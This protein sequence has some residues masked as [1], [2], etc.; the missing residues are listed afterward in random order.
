MLPKF[1]ADLSI[2]VSYVHLSLKS[3]RLM[4]HQIFEQK[5]MVPLWN[6]ANWWFVVLAIALSNAPLIGRFI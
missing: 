6:L 5:K 3:L 2:T 1:G 4:N